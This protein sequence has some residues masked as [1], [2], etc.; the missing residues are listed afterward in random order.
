MEA[1]SAYRDAGALRDH[2]AGAPRA[3]GGGVLVPAPARR[4]AIASLSAVALVLCALSLLSSAS[5]GEHSLLRQFDTGVE[6]NLATWFASAL[7]LAAGALA[8][9]LA[10]AGRRTGMRGWSRWALLAG[11]FML[12]SIDDSA[13]FHE[14]T[15]GPLMDA[16]RGVTGLQ[17]APARAVAAACVAVALLAGAAWLWPW[18]RS[19][20]RPL[21]L[22]LALAATVFV[23]GAFALEVVSRLV[24]TRYLSPFEELCEMLGVTVLIAALL[25]FVRAV[26]LRPPAPR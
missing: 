22:Q 15:V 14:Q 8:A 10:A 7:W 24:D 9:A 20:P 16:V 18:L 19:L 12:L 3:V 6:A 11:I 25:P 21:A 17:Q 23:G 5:D 26:L 4:S 2:D 13:Q 1:A